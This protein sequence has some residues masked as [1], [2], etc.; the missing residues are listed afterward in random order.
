MNIAILIALYSGE[1]LLLTGALG[2]SVIGCGMELR[3]ALVL[4]LLCM[5]GLL[6]LTPVFVQRLVMNR[7]TALMTLEYQHAAKFTSLADMKK[8]FG[9]PCEKAHDKPAGPPA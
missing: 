3:Q 5:V 1:G 6:V 7:E 2:L 4:G 8:H 9:L